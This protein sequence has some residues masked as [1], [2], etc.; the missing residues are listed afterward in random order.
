MAF[1]LFSFL[2][3]MEGEKCHVVRVSGKSLKQLRNGETEKEELD[4]TEHEE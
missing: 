2:G 4:K 3:F 1:Y